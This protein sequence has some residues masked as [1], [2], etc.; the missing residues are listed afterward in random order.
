MSFVIVFAIVW[1][2]LI[3]ASSIV[4]AIVLVVA[5]R[6]GWRRPDRLPPLAPPPSSAEA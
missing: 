4:A 1:L 6:L 3:L 2:P 5:R